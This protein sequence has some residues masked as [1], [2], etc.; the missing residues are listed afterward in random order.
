MV[1]QTISRE[2]LDLSGYRPTV[3][4]LKGDLQERFLD[5]I[6]DGFQMP[7]DSWVPFHLEVGR[8][9]VEGEWREE[10]R[11]DLAQMIHEIRWA[12]PED[13]GEDYEYVRW[14]GD[15]FSFYLSFNM[16]T[17]GGMRVPAYHKVKEL[18]QIE[19]EVP[20]DDH[21][22]YGLGVGWEWEPPLTDEEISFLWDFFRFAIEFEPGGSSIDSEQR[23]IKFYDQAASVSFLSGM[24]GEFSHI[25]CIGSIRL[26]TCS[27]GGCVVKS[28]G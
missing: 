19:A 8:K 9:L 10:K 11:D 5:I 13:V 27:L 23:F 22:A 14:A 12:D 3:T 6:A 18:M 2:E 4:R 26:S 15:P 17:T 7:E 20:E 28:W 16:R 24:R 1:G 21:G 25:C